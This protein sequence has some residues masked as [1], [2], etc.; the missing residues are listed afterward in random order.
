M[1][2]LPVCQWR[3][4]PVGAGSHIC[5]SPKIRSSHAGIPDEFCLTCRY[6]NHPAPPTPRSRCRHF[7]E[8]L[9]VA[10]VRLANRTD[11]ATV[12][13]RYHRCKLLG[14]CTPNVERAELPCCMTCPSYSADWEREHAGDVRHLTYY[15]YPA[16]PWWRWNLDELRKRIGLFNGRRLVAVATDEG[17]AQ[18]GEVKELLA[19]DGCEFL[20]YRNDPGKREMVAHLDLL[21]RLQDY[22]VDGDVT[23]YG[24]AKGVSSHLYGAGVRRW[25]EEMYRGNLDCWPAVQRA[26]RTHATCGVFRRILSPAPAAHVPWHY[27]GS[28][29]WVR[30]KDLYSRN[31][32]AIDMNWYGP[33]TYPGMQFTLAES[34]CLYGEFAYGGVGLYLESTWSEWVQAD[35]EKW[36]AAHHADVFRPPLVSCILTSHKQPAL[37]HEAV[38]SVIGQ[39]YPSWELIICD[40]GPLAAAGAFARYVGDARIRW[41]TSGQ[42]GGEPAGVNPH[43]W[44]I[45]ALVAGGWIRGELVMHLSDDDV[46]YPG[47]FGVFAINAVDHPDQKAWYGRADRGRLHPGGYYEQIGP[48]ALRGRGEPGN[49]LRG[50]VDGLQGCVR[51]GS[52]MPWPEDP[53]LSRENDGVWL[54]QLGAA[55]GV[56]PVEVCV[57]AHRHTPW[58]TWTQ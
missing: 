32:R 35:C 31:W 37:V 45:N 26:L 17:S 50:H 24:H 1:I 47:A 16:G 7:G 55:V 51:R 22:Q 56:D 5:V 34:A 58:S 23:F 20:L 54:D 27:S 29:R 33:E 52:W 25:I 15:V 8:L 53:A 46:Y 11:G 38:N 42:L 28:F 44:K 21:Q 10:P 19:G 30:N 49:P 39:A 43:S 36:R 13:T 12:L 9:K 57:G 3:R 41:V 40:S 48:L 14:E 18:A 2:E 6:V 4:Q